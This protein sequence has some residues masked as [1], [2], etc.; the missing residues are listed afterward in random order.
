MKVRVAIIGVIALLICIFFY[1]GINEYINLDY[2]KSQQASLSRYQHEKPFHTGLAFLCVYIII[3]ALSLPGAAV[4][5]LAGGA[6]FGLFNGVLLASIASTTGATLA[7]IGARF[8][9]RNMIQKKFSDK[10]GIINKG[11]E[12]D[13]GLYLFTLR[14]VPVFPF[15]MINLL[16]GLSPIRL[17]TFF[18]V[19][20]IGMLPGTIVYVY[21]GV[22]LGKIN[23][24]KDVLSHE[25]ILSFTLLGL[26]P[27]LSKKTVD[28]VKYIKAT[29]KNID[30]HDKDEKGI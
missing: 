21:A 6:I 29:R 28:I 16:M 19:S 8:L 12:K 5:T 2:L 30:K 18:L 25:L 17:L 24:L 3:T 13:G 23:T 1:L 20:Q 22:Q 10:L 26:L 27:L 11:I 7:F 14:L 4:L 9:F 15:F